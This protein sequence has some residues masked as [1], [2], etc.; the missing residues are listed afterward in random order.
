MKKMSKKN[1]YWQV[2]LNGKVFRDN[3]PALEKQLAGVYKKASGTIEKEIANLYVKMLEAGEVSLDMMYRDNRYKVLLDQINTEIIKLGLKEEQAT[4]DMLV[5]SFKEVFQSTNKRLGVTADW[6][7]LNDKMAKEVVMANF[8]GGTFSD[9]IWDNKDTLRTNLEQ[10]ITDTVVGGRSKDIAVKEI[11]ERFN[12]GYSDADRIV[13]TETQ[14][15]LN[16]GQKES[17]TQNG[18]TKYEY[19]ASLDE[20]TSD[21]CEELNGQIFEFSDAQTGLNF[22]PMHPNCRSTI[23]P[24]LD[25]DIFK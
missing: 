4:T 13:R 15:V 14:R 18:Y 19:L 9:R 1:N 2:R 25:G 11:R 7:I 6:T 24:V 16:D 23:I 5:K 21:I 17:Y 12:V 10:A 3:V 8:K 20:R 22:P